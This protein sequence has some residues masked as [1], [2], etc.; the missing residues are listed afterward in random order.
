[1]VQNS[2]LPRTIDVRIPISPGRFL[3]AEIAAPPKPAGLVVF[4][5]GSASSRHSA[6]NRFVSAELNDLRLVTVLPDLLTRE[7][8]EIDRDTG[9]LR[10]DVP[11]LSARLVTVMDWLRH[12]DEFGRL[13]LG[14]FGAS[15]GAAAALDAA[16]L[17]PETVRAI[18]CR[19]GRPDLALR[20]DQVRAPTLLVVGGADEVVLELNEEAMSQLE[21]RTRLEVVPGATHLFGEPGALEDVAV[22]A[23]Q[24]FAEFLTEGAK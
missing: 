6:R 7:E 18:V 22:I 2:V 10:F 14:L 17:R 4:A 24:W 13:P 16:A 19:G 1:M 23:G 11:M 3:D 9:V 20:L 8:Q 21:C 5:H 12:S 15:T